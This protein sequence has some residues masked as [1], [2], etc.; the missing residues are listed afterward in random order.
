[1]SVLRG[2]WPIL[3]AATQ[4]VLPLAIALIPGLNFWI[5]VAIILL[6]VLV[7]GLREY[8]RD[9]KPYADFTK[10]R[11]FF[12][13]ND[14]RQAFDR[15]REYD[16]TARLNVMEVRYRLPRKTW[17]RFEPIYQLGM[18]GAED[19]DLR[20]R[21]EQGAAGEA[22]RTRASYLANLENPNSPS[23]GLNLEQQRKTEGLTLIFSWPIMRLR[24]KE[25]GELY[26]TDEVIG[27]LNIDSSRPGALAFYEETKVADDGTT[28]REEV[29]TAQEIIAVTCSWIMS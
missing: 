5:K 27:V 10:K 13:E 16:E 12:F 20:L 21:V 3:L 29:E 28:L 22:F 9:V 15:L 7:A 17:G 26:P 4:P 18:E 1:M 2:L 23:Y 8:L 25:D 19:M 14:S 11:N 24:K 6:I